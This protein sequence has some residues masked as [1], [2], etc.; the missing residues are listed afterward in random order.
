MADAPLVVPARDRA[1]RLRETREE[2]RRGPRTQAL[3]RRRLSALDGRTQDSLR[4]FYGHEGKR[5]RRV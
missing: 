3:A 4:S 2:D 5:R 1:A